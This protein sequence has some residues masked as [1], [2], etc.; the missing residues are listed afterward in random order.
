MSTLKVATIQDTSGNNSSTPA[1]VAEG[2]AKAWIN[3]NGIGTVAIRDDFNFSSVTDNGTGLYTVNFTSA[4]ANANYAVVTGGN[5]EDPEDSRCFPPNID[6]IS[7]SSFR[8]AT[9]NDGFTSVDWVLVTCAVF[10]D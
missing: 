6:Q 9:H 10:G 5:R 8:L 4:L 7:T 3:F 1:Q 2:R